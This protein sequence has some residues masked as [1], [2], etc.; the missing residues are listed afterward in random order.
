MGNGKCPNLHG[1]RYSR[2]FGSKLVCGLSSVAE[3]WMGWP[4]P[5]F[6]LSAWGSWCRAELNCT[7]AVGC[8]Q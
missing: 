8:P 1:C 2:A 6:N 7:R 5:G 4:N 3:G